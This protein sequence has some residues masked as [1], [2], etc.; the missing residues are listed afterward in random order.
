MERPDVETDDRRGNDRRGA[1]GPGRRTRVRLPRR[2]GAADLRRDL[3]P[4]PGPPY[5]GAPRA[6]RGARRRGLRAL[7][8][9]G[10][11]AARHLRT[12][13]DQ[14]RHRP[15]RR[16]ARLD[17]A[18]LHHRPGA[19][20]S[21]RLGRVPGMRHD[22]HHPQLHQAQLSRPQDR[23]A[24]AHP[25]RGVL[26]RLARPPGPGRH[27]RAQGRAVRQRNLHVPARHPAQDLSA[28]DQ[29][30]RRQD[31][32]RGRDDGQGEEADLLHRRRRD[33]CRARRP[34]RC[35]ASWCG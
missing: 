16:A 24:A 12:R 10:R 15:D 19:D 11:R 31:R 26:R 28:A 14:R 6:G 29:G 2:F 21:H 18:R 1:Q 32:A 34:R 33:Q 7:D 5:P 30:R 17:P 27:R 4:E 23:G 8:R 25:A 20:P 22:R 3:R 9:Q 13:R 35:C